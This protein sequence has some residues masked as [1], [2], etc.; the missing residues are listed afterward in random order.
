[1]DFFLATA[2]RLGAPLANIEKDFWVCWTLNVLYHRLPAVGPRLLFKG[3][4]SLSKAYGLINPDFGNID[5]TVFRD[6]LGHPA[7]ANEIATLSVKKRKAAL[8]AIAEDCKVF[9]TGGLL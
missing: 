1:M 2:Q 9:I 5:V 8:E 3:G 6:D 4:T 7:T